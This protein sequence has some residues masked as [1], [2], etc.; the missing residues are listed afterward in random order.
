[1]P[2]SSASERNA[3]ASTISVLPASTASTAAPHSRITSKVVRPTAGRSNRASWPGLN[4]F[5]TTTPAP[6]MRL[7][8]R[9]VSSV[10]ST[11]SSASTWPPF[12][13]TVCP[14]SALPRS[15]ATS[16]PS[17]TSFSCPEVSAGPASR[18]WGASKSVKKSVCGTM[19]IPCSSKYE[20]TALSSASSRKL[21][22][23]IAT[24]NAPR[25]GLASRIARARPIPPTITA[26]TTWALRKKRTIRSS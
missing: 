5:T 18:P 19:E 13:T 24:R 12:T 26:L 20:A 21:R 16:R 15:C 8:R 17:A 9:I 23:R 11:A 10:P 2:A 6:A 25:S 7:P 1:M 3:A 22:K 14:T 4:T